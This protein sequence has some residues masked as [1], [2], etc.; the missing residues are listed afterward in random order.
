MNNEYIEQPK[1]FTQMERHSSKDGKVQPKC[2]YDCDYWKGICGRTP[3]NRIAIAKAPACQ[4]FKLT[5][6][7]LN[8]SQLL[9]EVK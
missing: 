9:M 6:I 2:C 3:P 1:K 7:K 8:K 5:Q 4:F